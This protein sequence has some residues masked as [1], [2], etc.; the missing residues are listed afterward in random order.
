MSRLRRRLPA[1][2]AGSLCAL[3]M[4]ASCTVG[5]DFKPP[6]APN[7]Q[8]YWQGALGDPIDAQGQSQGFV[9]GGD[10]Q[11]DWWTLFRSPALDAL[12]KQAISRN[13]SLQAAE[14][15]LLQSQDL[16]KAGQGVYYPQVSGRFAGSR[17]QGNAGQPGLA[18]ADSIF[19][20]VTLSGTVS[21]ALDLF[22]G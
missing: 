13:P 2:C 15:S 9:P 12:V 6:E 16:L 18:T 19:N 10:L 21:Y 14:A 22:G 5:P 17:Q 8:L 3:L 7:R 4:I 20:V 1:A 11:W